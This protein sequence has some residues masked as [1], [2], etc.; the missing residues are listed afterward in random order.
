MDIK[1]LKKEMLKAKR[2]DK[3]RANALM[4]LV[5]TAQKLAKERGV[6]VG[7]KEIQESAKKLVKIAKESL[8]AG[9]PNAQREL[10]IYSQFL[11]K[12]LSEEETKALLQQLIEELG[13]KNI[14]AIMR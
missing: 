3:I 4:M 13:G 11:P 6:E 5:D 14:G 8:E 12:T 9:V 7:E 2:S 1:E 10:E